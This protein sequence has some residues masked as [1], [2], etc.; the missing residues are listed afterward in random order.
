MNNKKMSV[1]KKKRKKK[2]ITDDLFYLGT[3]IFGCVGLGSIL[4]IL[5][6][7][8]SSSVTVYSLFDPNSIGELNFEIF[9]MFFFIFFI[10]IA[11]TRHLRNRL[12]V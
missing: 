3:A 2:E 4:Y 11:F 9:L 5:L 12:R 8:K 1:Y 7:A 10:I 6:K